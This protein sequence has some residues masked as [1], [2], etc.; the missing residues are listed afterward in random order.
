MQHALG[1]LDTHV[2]AFGRH[3]AEYTLQHDFTRAKRDA[4]RASTSTSGSRGSVGSMN[5]PIE[6]PIPELVEEPGYVRKSV[7]EEQRLFR[8]LEVER[9]KEMDREAW[10]EV[11]RER[12]AARRRS[13]AFERG[14]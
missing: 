5:S 6:S 8:E 1:Y 2:P 12:E 14:E 13:G 7:E 11:V 10:E 9:R 4:M 3:H